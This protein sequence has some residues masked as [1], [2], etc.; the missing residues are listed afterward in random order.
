MQYI[1]E[2]NMPNSYLEIKI[3][4]RANMIAS[5]MI[6]DG[7][8]ISIALYIAKYASS[9]ELSGDKRDVLFKL[10]TEWE[11]EKNADKKDK[12]LF[13][14]TSIVENQRNKNLKTNF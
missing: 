10:I 8:P 13:N 6:S 2:I 14:I 11:K 1:E 3:V 7:I 9:I 5:K 4:Q 12:I